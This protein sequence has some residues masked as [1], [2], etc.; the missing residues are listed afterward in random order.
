MPPADGQ[1]HADDGTDHRPDPR[2]VIPVSK[3]VNQGGDGQRQR[4][5]TPKAEQASARERG[6]GP[7]IEGD[8]G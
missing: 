2:E 3:A 5:R 4:R 1:R 6:G 7:G 8:D